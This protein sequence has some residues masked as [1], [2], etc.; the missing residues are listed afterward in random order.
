MWE[1]TQYQWRRLHNIMDTQRQK[2]NHWGSS[3]TRCYTVR[4][5]LLIIQLIIHKL[6]YERIP[7]VDHRASFILKWN[8]DHYVE[9]LSKS[10][11]TQVPSLPAENW[12]MLIV[13]DY[14]DVTYCKSSQKVWIIDNIRSESPLIAC[15]KNWV[16]LQEAI[17]IES[18]QQ[19]PTE[20]ASDYY[21]TWVIRW[22]SNP[23]QQPD[24]KLM[25]DLRWEASS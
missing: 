9:R 15:K 20:P 12:A 23:G 2:K 24:Y 22:N 13:N 3:R 10:R 14:R 4:E 18:W 7:K 5:I 16:L 1:T 19:P 6:R 17:E 25:T 11:I 21:H 8:L